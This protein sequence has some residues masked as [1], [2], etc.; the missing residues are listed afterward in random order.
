MVF[1]E[2]NFPNGRGVEFLEQLESPRRKNFTRSVSLSSFLL[3]AL[4]LFFS[5][6]LSLDLGAQYTVT[7]CQAESD[8]VV[9]P[10]R[11]AFAHGP[12]WLNDGYIHNFDPP[13][14]P[15]GIISPAF[16]SVTVGINLTG[17]SLVSCPDIL[18]FG[19]VLLN[20]ALNGVSDLAEDILSPG[21]RENWGTGS[22]TIGT[23][24]EN[25]F[26]CN[27][28]I[29]TSDV[30][31][32]DIIPATDRS[33][34]VVCQSNSAVGSGAVSL[35][36]EIC[37]TYVYDQDTPADCANTVLLPCDD[38]NPCTT[39]DVESVDACDNTVICVLCEGTPLDCTNGATS[40][41]ACDDGDPCTINDEQTVLDCDGSVC[42]PCTGAIQDCSTGTT[43]VVTCD[44]GDPCTVGDMQ[45][46]LDCDGSVCV[47]CTG[48]V[49][50]CAAG[51][52]RI[53]T[54][55]DGNEFTLNDEQ[56]VL[57]CNGS[58]CVPCAGTPV[59]CSNGTTTVVACD[60][61]D[62]CTSGDEQTVLDSDGRICR[63]C[64][65][66]VLDC[67]TGPSSLVAC[68]DGNEFTFNDE[69][70]VLNCNG[71]ICVPCAGTPVDCSNG[72][73]T[74]V[75]C[76][77]GDPCTSGDEQTVLDSDGRACTPCAG[78]V[79]DC[80]TG[81]N[82]LVACD[83][84]NEFTLNDEQIVLNCNGSICV[85]CAGTQVDCS[86]GTTTVVVC[87][88]GDP[89]TSGDEQ[90][91]LDSDGRICIPCAGVVEDCSTG[92]SSVLVCD[93]GNAD[94]INDEETVLDCDGSI[95]IPCAGTLKQYTVTSCQTV[96]EATVDLDRNDFAHDNQPNVN[97]G[98]L[99]NFTPLDLPC[100]I[101]SPVLVSVG[102][103]ID[104]TDVSATGGCVGVPVF[105]NVLLNC[106]LTPVGICPI[107]QDVL[108]PGCATFGGGATSTGTYSL[109]VLS[110]S[111]IGLNDVIG[112]DIVPA[113]DFSASCPSNSTAISNGDISL[114]Y[115]IC[116]TYVYN[117]D[118]PVDCANTVLLACDDN[119][120]CTT[121]DME[122]VEDCDNTIVCV[123]CAGVVVDC[124]TGPS[125]VVAC[126]D[127]NVFTVSDEQTVLDCNGSICIPCAG[128]QVDCSNGT[129][130]VVVCD[131]GDPCTSGDE[132]T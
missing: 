44:D 85:P 87:D 43:S 123:P 8:A 122:S 64:A 71:S 86:N 22:G 77:D 110:C 119:D 101:G 36:Y 115:T 60:D 91:V 111:T 128:T 7:V 23:Y 9:G 125:S 108:T 117:Y 124:A 79:V 55:N 120:P 47:P 14:F 21:C 118:D 26:A 2:Y 42:V 37:I 100:E 28:T 68:D 24:S 4:M 73:T 65:G 66:V 69:Q 94:T 51:P 59:D 67:F 38:G 52:T 1:I 39:G 76:D 104:L 3:L 12:G 82:S 106:S 103:E 83:D 5:L 81:P 31:G 105:G 30:I 40:I 72:T 58:T 41:M 53:I 84:G 17:I 90:T 93:D 129:T 50:D 126:D 62:P 19:N 27:P 114:M 102:I 46:V 57:D 15:C 74:V 20:T 10:D 88:D 109:D 35:E 6:G 92:P 48:V 16:T 34:S 116:I 98:Y 131:D 29:R 61:G 130:T 32:V 121:G 70:I 107:I 97:E 96:V 18:F 25:I 95:C 112:V 63:P 45:T 54:C 11:N 33:S 132:Q 89:C 13:V 56:I 113:T 99:H 75:A 78:V 80:F 49:Q 127:G